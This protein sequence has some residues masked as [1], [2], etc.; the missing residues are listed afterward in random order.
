MNVLGLD[1]AVHRSGYALV[2]GNK[3]LA[4]QVAA[5][6]V[7]STHTDW[8]SAVVEHANVLAPFMSQAELIVAESQVVVRGR[9]R[10]ACEVAKIHGGMAILI[11]HYRIPVMFVA[12]AQLRAYAH[13]PPKAGKINDFHHLGYEYSDEADAL[14]LAFMGLHRSGMIQ[15]DVDQAKII[16]RLSWLTPLQLS[17]SL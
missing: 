6:G 16:R 10:A 1:L 9:A 4:P 12:P 5:I 7:V 17:L 3:D 14:F 8:I 2:I 15:G 11:A 13:V